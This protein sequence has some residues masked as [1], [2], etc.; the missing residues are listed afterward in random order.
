MYLLLESYEARSVY[1][2]KR[3]QL[4]IMIFIR[5]ENNIK[6]IFK[7]ICSSNSNLQTVLLFAFTY[8]CL[9]IYYEKIYFIIIIIIIIII[10]IIIFVFVCFIKQERKTFS[11]FHN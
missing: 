6:I 4:N 9:Q 11:F 10:D 1:D 8:L 5:L 2:G 7:H 3:K